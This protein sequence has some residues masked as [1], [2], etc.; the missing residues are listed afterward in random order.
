MSR[1]ISLDAFVF[2]PGTRCPSVAHSENCCI[3]V[4]RSC[5]TGRGRYDNRSPLPTY[6]LGKPTRTPPCR[7]RTVSGKVRRR[8]PRLR[9]QRKQ[10]ETKQRICRIKNHRFKASCIQNANR[11][12]HANLE[13]PWT[14]LCRIISQVDVRWLLL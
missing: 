8:P 11:T 9:S 13:P 6:I 7:L 10:A 3:F 12:S 4:C 14:G 2:A 1:P 5:G